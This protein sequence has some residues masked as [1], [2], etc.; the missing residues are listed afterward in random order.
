[1]WQKKHLIIKL[2]SLQ[3][4]KQ[5]SILTLCNILEFCMNFVDGPLYE[6]IYNEDGTTNNALIHAINDQY[7]GYSTANYVNPT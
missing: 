3:K 7:E 4:K 1:M 2:N 5:Q 6:T